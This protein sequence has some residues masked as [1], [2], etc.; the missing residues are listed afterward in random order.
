M[1]EI[2]AKCTHARQVPWWQRW[3]WRKIGVCFEWLMVFCGE[4][5]NDADQS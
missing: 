2:D 3:F 5:N 4:G 1:I